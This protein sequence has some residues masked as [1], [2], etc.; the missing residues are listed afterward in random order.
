[1]SDDLTGRINAWECK[2]PVYH[3]DVEVCGLHTYCVHVHHGVT[4]MFL[5][6][7]AS[8]H[9]PDSEENTCKGQAVSLT[10][11]ESMPPR[12]AIESVKWE[13]YKP[14]DDEFAQLDDGSRQHVEMGGLLLRPL[15]DVGREILMKH[16]G[17]A[18]A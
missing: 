16:Y 18:P 10:Y 15:T 3:P 7:R 14:E 6:C 11:P 9:E 4:P 13:W 2:P 17:P 1:M 5:A 12:H 8:G